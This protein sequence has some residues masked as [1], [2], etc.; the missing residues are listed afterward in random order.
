MPNAPEFI[1]TP[2]E[3]N[4]KT[5]FGDVK[6]SDWYYQY[7]L[8]LK[9]AGIISG[10]DDG[11][12]YPNNLVKREE[13]LKMLVIASKLQLSDTSEGF[14]D[15][16]TDDWFAPYV[17]T[18]KESGIANGVSDTSFGVGMPISRQDMSVMIFNILGIDLDTTVNTG[19]FADDD[20]IADY[21]YKP[22]YVMKQI[23]LINGYE[24]GEFNPAGQL[25]RAEATKVISMVM[26]YFK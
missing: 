6:M 15:V 12:F 17:Y 13:F 9:E 26:N 7:L 18:A 24:N 11:N 22:V 10:Y 20:S 4:L 19:L 16:N 25:T 23:G 5:E 14:A 8:K 1:Q 3:E 2:S 21:A